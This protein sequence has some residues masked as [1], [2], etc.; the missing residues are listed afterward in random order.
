MENISHF[1]SLISNMTELPRKL[2]WKNNGGWSCAE[3]PGPLVDTAVYGGR[4]QLFRGPYCGKTGAP[5]AVLLPVIPSCIERVWR[6][7]PGGNLEKY[8]Y[9]LRARIARS[10]V[11][12]GMVDLNETKLPPSLPS[13]VKPL[14]DNQDSRAIHVFF[15]PF[16]VHYVLPAWQRYRFQDLVNQSV[17]LP[18]GSNIIHKKRMEENMNGAAILGIIRKGFDDGRERT[19]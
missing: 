17:T 10:P 14:S 19:E 8:Q 12:L 6:L 16:L 9:I 7:E 2:V 4:K 5:D 11:G 18:G 15:H 13:I 3:A 1:K